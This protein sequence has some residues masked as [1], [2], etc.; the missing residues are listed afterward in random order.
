MDYLFMI[1]SYALT[2]KEA[3]SGLSYKLVLACQTNLEILA[4]DVTKLEN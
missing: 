3:T 2:D 4:Y 1:R